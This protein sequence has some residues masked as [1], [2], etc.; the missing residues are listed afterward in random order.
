[1]DQESREGKDSVLDSDEGVTIGENVLDDADIDLP[2]LNELTVSIRHPPRPHVT[3][4][5]PPPIASEESEKKTPK[6]RASGSAAK[7]TSHAEDFSSGFDPHR[8]PLTDEETKTK[9]SRALARTKLVSG[10]MLSVKPVIEGMYFSTHALM[11]L[12]IEHK[13]GPKPGSVDVLQSLGPHPKKRSPEK[14]ELTI[15]ASVP[16]HS[17]P[18]IVDTPQEASQPTPHDSASTNPPSKKLKVAAS[19]ENEEGQGSK[20]SSFATPFVCNIST[21]TC[22]IYAGDGIVHSKVS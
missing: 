8:Y 12:M 4:I 3:Y 18:A 19:G 5:G 11:W 9:K 16:T 20:K 17:V 2:L 21:E 22:R 13:L 6:K 15:A 7:N 1:M 10:W 14:S